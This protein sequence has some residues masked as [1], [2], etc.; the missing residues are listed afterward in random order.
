MCDTRNDIKAILMCWSEQIL[1][2]KQLKM[3]QAY[4]SVL[5]MR[6]LTCWLVVEEA[7]PDLASSC[8][9][10]WN[11][12]DAR[13]LF[14]PCK[15]LYEADCNV[16][17]IV[18]ERIEILESVNC[19]AAN[20]MNVADVRCASSVEKSHYSESGVFSCRELLCYCHVVECY[21]TIRTVCK[22]QR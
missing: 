5:P 17:A 14:A 1:H 18:L 7:T 19:L 6:I 22:I 10:W 20:W 4:L 13:K 16:K 9:G 12:G 8:G 3:K 11:S 21:C 2:T 15:L